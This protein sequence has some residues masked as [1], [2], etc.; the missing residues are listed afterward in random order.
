MGAF[1]EPPDA[2]WTGYPVSA[3]QVRR[4]P[5]DLS[6]EITDE[7]ASFYLI[8]HIKRKPIQTDGFFGAASQI[9]T[10]DLILTNG[11]FSVMSRCE[12]AWKARNCKAFLISAFEKLATVL[13][14]FELLV[15]KK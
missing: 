3:G 11:I 10:G 6:I 2:I 15:A 13:S 14:R 7:V 4:K 9:W 12:M 5:Y 1:F 8:K